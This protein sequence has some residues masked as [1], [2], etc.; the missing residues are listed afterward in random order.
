MIFSDSLGVFGISV[1]FPSRLFDIR[2]W[3][4]CIVFSGCSR[5]GGSGITFGSDSRTDLI[6]GTESRSGPDNF[7]DLLTDWLTSEVVAGVVGFSSQRRISSP[8]D[9]SG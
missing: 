6:A 7:S 1:M 3:I 8:R 5:G 4:F 2:Q 9:V